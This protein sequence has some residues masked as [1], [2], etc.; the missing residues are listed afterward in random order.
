MV[1]NNSIVCLELLRFYHQPPSLSLCE[2]F[3]DLLTR[4]KMLTPAIPKPRVFYQKKIGHKFFQIKPKI[5]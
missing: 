1:K 4:K 3:S 5:F 2:Y